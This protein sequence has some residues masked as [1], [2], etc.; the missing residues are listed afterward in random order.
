MSNEQQA[1]PL[2]HDEESAFLITEITQ[3]R[4]ALKRRFESRRDVS[5]FL[6]KIIL[7]LVI[8]IVVS[9]FFLILFQVASIG[10][11][12]VFGTGSGQGLEFFGTFPGIGLEGG[13]RNA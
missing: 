4:D 6:F 9:P 13:I 1:Q 2:S 10:F 5:D 3:V 12:Q 11:W 7:G 8:L